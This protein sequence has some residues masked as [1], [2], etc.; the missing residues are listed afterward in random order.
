MRTLRIW[1]DV[2]LRLALGR[3][4]SPSWWSAFFLPSLEETGGF[5]TA[6]EL[7]ARMKSRRVWDAKRVVIE[8]AGMGLRFC[9]S[10]GV[11]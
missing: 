11:W 7:T 4:S 6:R 3:L 2:S 10:F 1:V 5:V 9:R 8:R